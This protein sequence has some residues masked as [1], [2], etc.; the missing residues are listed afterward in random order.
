M[1]K[2]RDTQSREGK[3]KPARTLKEKRA[4]KAAKRDG[5]SSSD[6]IHK[7]LGDKP[8]SH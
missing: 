8:K 2:G 1:S 7:A 4:D 3:K 6:S 5:T